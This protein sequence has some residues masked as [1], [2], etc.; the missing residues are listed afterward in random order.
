MNEL[1]LECAWKKKDFNYIDQILND[2]PKN[3]FTSIL[4][5]DSKIRNIGCKW[6]LIIRVIFLVD[7]LLYA[8]LKF[9]IEML[10]GLADPAVLCLVIPP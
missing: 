3:S 6:V 7:R 1:K 5:I 10:S 9:D 2:Q 4:Q 8:Y